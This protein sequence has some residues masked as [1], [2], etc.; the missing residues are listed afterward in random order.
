MTRTPV[1][2]TGRRSLADRRDQKASARTTTLAAVVRRK[3]RIRRGVR[4]RR[5]VRRVELWSLFRLAV[6]FHLLCWAVSVAV[7]AILTKAIDQAGLL[8]RLERFLQDA[9]FAKGFKVNLSVLLRVSASVGLGLVIVAVIAT[10]LLGFFFNGLSGLLGG[11]VIT[12]LEE[13][14]PPAPSAQ[15]VAD[16][17]VAVAPSSPAD[18]SPT[19]WDES[20]WEEPTQAIPSPA[21]F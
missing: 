21:R 20:A 16:S 19:M 9:G 2:G 14:A 11:L 5:V 4:V 1:V 6:A 7:L 8:G 15:P 12:V 18:D 10:M 3:R 13:R 17:A